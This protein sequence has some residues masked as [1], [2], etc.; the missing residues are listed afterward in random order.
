MCPFGSSGIIKKSGALERSSAAHSALSV[1]TGEQS[2]VLKDLAM[3]AHAVHSTLRSRM[4]WLGR[5]QRESRPQTQVL[6]THYLSAG[7]FAQVASL[8]I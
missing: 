6:S 3:R 8:T 5:A 4:Q 7:A 1:K 2:R